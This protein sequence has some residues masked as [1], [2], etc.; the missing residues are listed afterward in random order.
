[1]T[2]AVMT[3]VI[4]GN[5]SATRDTNGKQSII[6]AQDNPD[7]GI[8]IMDSQQNSVDLN[9]L[10][11]SVGVPFRLVENQAASAQ[12]ADVTFLALPVSTTGKVPAA[13]R[14][15]ALAVLRVE[16]Q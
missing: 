15:N 3:L 8:M 7:V 16:Y 9:A 5:I 2:D 4:D 11:T 6:Q 12:T 10:A 1:D 14:Y 13:G